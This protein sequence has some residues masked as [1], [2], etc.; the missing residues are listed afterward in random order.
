MW[1]GSH[2]LSSPSSP[3]ALANSF[4]TFGC[5]HHPHSPPAT[6]KIR[7]TQHLET[8]I[9]TQDEQVIEE[10]VTFPSIRPTKARDSDHTCCTNVTLALWL[11]DFILDTHHTEIKAKPRSDFF[12]KTI[13]L[14]CFT[15]LCQYLWA[16]GAVSHFLSWSSFISFMK[17]SILFTVPRC[18]HD[19]AE[20]HFEF[21]ILPTEVWTVILRNNYPLCLSLPFKLLLLPRTQTLR[22]TRRYVHTSTDTYTD[23]HHFPNR[24]TCGSSQGIWQRWLRWP[25]LFWPVQAT[26]CMITYFIT[27]S[28][29]N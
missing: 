21:R 15:T 4:S 22:Q 14:S 7:F 28:E 17:L 1:T 9:L 11:E 27:W 19:L 20:S 29:V 26:S 12:L 2:R 23:T 6:W 18:K 13:I 5:R 24:N 8:T 10:I 16:S 3:V 25:E